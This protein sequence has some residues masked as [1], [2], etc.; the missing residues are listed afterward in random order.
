M[1]YGRWGSALG[2]RPLVWV[3]SEMLAVSQHKRL[4]LKQL[5]A[6]MDEDA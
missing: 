4:E 6:A 5:K 1:R 3:L 2:R